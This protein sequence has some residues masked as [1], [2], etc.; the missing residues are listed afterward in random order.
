MLKKKV[1]P[2]DGCQEGS[3][4]AGE[5]QVSGKL[6]LWAGGRVQG[7]IEELQG[8]SSGPC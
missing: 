1:V 5:P 4:A 7:A 8:P 3:K 6:C 2:R